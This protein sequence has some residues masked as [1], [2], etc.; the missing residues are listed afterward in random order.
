MKTRVVKGL[1]FFIAVLFISQL[2]AQNH[3]VK[4]VVTAFDSLFVG[5]IYL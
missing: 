2:Y 1:T 5:S 3:E 4:G